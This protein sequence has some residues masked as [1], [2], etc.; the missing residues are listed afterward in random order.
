MEAK[1]ATPL[2]NYITCDLLKHPSHRI[3]TLTICATSC[4]YTNYCTH[5]MLNSFP[6][7]KF[8]AYLTSR[9]CFLLQ[10]KSSL[11]FFHILALLLLYIGFHHEESSSDQGL[12]GTGH[13]QCK[14]P[15]K[16][17]VSVSRHPVV[18][19]CKQYKHYDSK[20]CTHTCQTNS[21]SKSSLCFTVLNIF[22]Q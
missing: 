18:S 13:S 11:G 7:G 2:L 19:V 1:Y 6:G 15:A 3:A 14:G 17:V 5:I 9:F 16:K 4:F 21:L 20:P 10:F 22:T 12:N 8:I